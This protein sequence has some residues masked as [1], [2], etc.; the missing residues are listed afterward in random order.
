MIIAGEEDA[1]SPS[2]SPSCSLPTSRGGA[3]SLDRLGNE[4]EWEIK[5]ERG[6]KQGRVSVP[7]GRVGQVKVRRCRHPLFPLLA[8]IFEK[9][10]LATCTPREPGVAGGDVCSSE[11]FNEDIAVFSKQVR[12]CPPRRAVSKG[13]GGGVSEV[14]RGVALHLACVA[15]FAAE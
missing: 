1:V 14:P 12:Q 9:C 11:S 8:L 7:G 2:C 4:E 6:E 15:G 5:A 13:G 10:E 3:G